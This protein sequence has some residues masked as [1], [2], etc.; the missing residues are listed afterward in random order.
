MPAG[1]AQGW[2]LGLIRKGTEEW[3]SQ[4]NPDRGDTSEVL[5]LVHPND[6][7]LVYREGKEWAR[8]YWHESAFIQ[9]PPEEYE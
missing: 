1:I 9:V 2:K 7:I 6:A 5:V 8:L 3:R 4:F